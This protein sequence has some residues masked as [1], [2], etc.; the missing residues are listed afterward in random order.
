MKL[1]CVPIVA[2]LFLMACQLITADYSREKHGYSAEKSS[3]KIQDSFYSKLTKRCTDEGGDCDPGNHN[4]C[5][6][7]CLVLQH[8]AICG[9][10][11]TMV[12][13]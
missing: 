12:S 11:Y 10:V 5:R 2:M 7:S 6:G 1:T 9:I 13:R 4:C 3:D 8:K